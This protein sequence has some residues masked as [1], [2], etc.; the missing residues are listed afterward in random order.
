MKAG[1]KGVKVKASRQ[2][3]QAKPIRQA[4]PIKQV[5]SVGPR[6]AIIMPAYNEADTIGNTISEIDLKII[7]KMRG[8][9]LFVFE[10]GS[11]DDTKIV[12]R[13][14]ADQHSWLEVHIGPQ[15]LG[16]PGAV[17]NAFASIDENQFDY[18]LFTDSDGQY[19]PSDFFKLLSVMKNGNLDMVVA[20]RMNRAEPFY[21]VILSRGLH[22]IERTLF[23][24]IHY[25]DV[26][27]AFRLMDPKIA[28]QLAA[29]VKFSKYNFWLEFTARASMM[30]VRTASVEVSYRQREGGATKV[31]HIGKIP[32]IVLNEFGAL[33]KTRLGG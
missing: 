8:V 31:Y 9:K 24:N 27:S 23:F 30:K 25:R 21:R 13:K 12:I 14:L 4:K 16:Y 17:K 20:Q 3:K 29:N 19:D 2:V 5:R 10:D 22:V 26:T 7:R 33:I 18:I 28:K 1:K 32:K 15:R 11:T 6:V